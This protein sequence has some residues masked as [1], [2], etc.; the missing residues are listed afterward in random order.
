MAG[1]VPSERLAASRVSWSIRFGTKVMRVL[2]V[3][4]LHP[5][6]SMG[7]A[8]LSA[9]NIYTSL[10][11]ADQDVHFLA[12]SPPKH[13]RNKDSRLL[14][15][16]PTDHVIE[17]GDYDYFWNFLKDFSGI[18]IAAN[19]VHRLAPDVVHLHHF[20]HIGWNGIRRIASVNKNAKFILTFH[21]YLLMCNNHGQMITTKSQTLCSRADSLSC[22]RCFP[23][24]P[25]LH[26]LKRQVAALEGLSCVHLVTAP[27]HFL[28]ERLIEFGVPEHKCVVIENLLDATIVSRAIGTPQKE[29][30]AKPANKVRVG[31]FGRL[32]ENKG[33]YVFLSAAEC[34]LRSALCD[35]LEFH[36]WGDMSGQPKDEQDR[37]ETALKSTAQNL[38]YHGPY[39]N[40]ETI[41]L[42]GEVDYVVVPSVWWENAPL[43]IQEAFLS[44]RP[45]IASNIGG[46][47]EKVQDGKNGLHFE[48]GNSRDLVEKLGLA[49]TPGVR[50]TLRCGALAARARAV[51][52]LDYV[53]LYEELASIQP[54]RAGEARRR[55]KQPAGL[56]VSI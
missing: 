39:D 22:T 32:T 46:M 25:E 10:K 21:E 29:T 12:F 52:A 13:H 55:G 44:G 45:V 28:M 34:V 7:G 18:E 43:V 41:T 17:I 51:T 20:L 2:V 8:Q 31:F 38:T 3:T 16:D 9:W 1:R 49:I 50:E 42:M 14:H 23:T 54:R 6:L 40:A 24:V 35:S 30:G 37:I 26:F 19:F 36:V 15:L 27:S 11:H 48:V 4:H 53:H 47:R 5:K 56:E 33:I